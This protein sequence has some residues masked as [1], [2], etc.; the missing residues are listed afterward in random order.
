MAREAKEAGRPVHLVSGS[1]QAFVDNVAASLPLPGEHYGSDSERNLTDATK[2][3]FL[4]S[5]FGSGGYDY[6][7]NAKADMKSWENAR[8]VLAVNPGA[9]LL[10]NIHA[11]SKP[12]ECTSDGLSITGDRIAIALPLPATICRCDENTSNR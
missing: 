2:A 9:T 5:Q 12:V 11:L 10:R 4:K 6:A 7:G 3:A 8:K 1:N